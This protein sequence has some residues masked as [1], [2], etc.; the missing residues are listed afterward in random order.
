MRLVIGTLALL[1]T[2]SLCLS[3][4]QRAP[5]VAVFTAE[6]AASGKIEIQK[7]AFGACTD[8]HAATLTGRKGAPGELP[9][10][11]SLSADYQKLVNGNGG[12]VPPFVGPGFVQKW[13]PR[14]TQDLIKEFEDRF[15][16]PGSRMTRETRLNLI[17]YILQ[18]NGAAAGTQPLTPETD[19]PL[20]DVVQ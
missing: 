4:G 18:A 8:C 14:T 3:A 9:P 12:I 10:L 2:T 16:P 6:Q 7:N 13:A 17:A 20:K 1:F 15:A 5:R 19:V 11:D